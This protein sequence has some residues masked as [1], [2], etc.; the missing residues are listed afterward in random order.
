LTMTIRPL[1]IFVFH[2]TLQALSGPDASDF[3]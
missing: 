2:C 1:F 3:P